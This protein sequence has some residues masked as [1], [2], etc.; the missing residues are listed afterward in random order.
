MSAFVSGLAKKKK[1]DMRNSPQ[2]YVSVFFSLEIS[3]TP[4]FFRVEKKFFDGLLSRF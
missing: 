2:V 1:Q 4:S 3:G